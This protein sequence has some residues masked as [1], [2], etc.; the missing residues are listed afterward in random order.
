MIIYTEGS[1]KV[2]GENWPFLIPEIVAHGPIEFYACGGRRV[3]LYKE[4]DLSVAPPA[5]QG[6]PCVELPKSRNKIGGEKW[7]NLMRF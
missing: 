6:D 3:P 5:P 2:S 4:W 7:K 1:E